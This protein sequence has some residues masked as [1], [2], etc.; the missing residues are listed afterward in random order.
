TSK[1]AIPASRAPIAS[2]ATD[3]AETTNARSWRDQGIGLRWARLASAKPRSSRV[4]ATSKARSKEKDNIALTRVTCVRARVRELSPHAPAWGR[5]KR[6]DTPPRTAPLGSPCAAK[7]RLVR[8][9]EGARVR[10]ASARRRA[11]PASTGIMRVASDA[12]KAERN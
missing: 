11:S 1:A 2:A 10:C 12:V 8:R 7:I 6:A 3:E 9:L 5:P 4:A